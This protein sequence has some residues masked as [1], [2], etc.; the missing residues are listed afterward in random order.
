MDSTK[1][2]YKIIRRRTFKWQFKD[3]KPFD[4]SSIGDLAFLLLIFFIVTS[5]FILRQGIFLSL[6]SKSSGAIKLQENQIFEVY[7]ENEGF[8]YEGKLIDRDSLKTFLS[9]QK[10]KQPDSVFVV[11]MKPDVLYD[12]L[13]DAL[14][15]ASEVG[16]NRVSLKNYEE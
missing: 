1:I 4:S 15:V 14:S 13:V 5:S 6:P 2:I 10:E 16:M 7:P 9:G 3:A 11:Y 8:V 12:R